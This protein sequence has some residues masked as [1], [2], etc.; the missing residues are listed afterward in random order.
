MKCDFCGGP[1]GEDYGNLMFQCPECTRKADI[2]A[3]PL[4]KRTVYKMKDIVKN[5]RATFA[6]ADTIREARNKAAKL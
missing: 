2:D 1:N 6:C 5:F 4:R 3:M